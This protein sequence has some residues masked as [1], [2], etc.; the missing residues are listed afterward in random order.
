MVARRPC[1]RLFASTWTVRHDCTGGRIDLV[2][3][4]LACCFST[5]GCNAALSVKS[6][7]EKGAAKF[8]GLNGTECGPLTAGRATKSVYDKTTKRATEASEFIDIAYFIVMA[9]EAKR[10]GV[11]QSIHLYQD[12]WAKPPLHGHVFR[13]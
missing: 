13:A 11:A 12:P 6:N 2:I 3:T 5:G 10:S 4:S 8:D 7:R 9:L 1:G